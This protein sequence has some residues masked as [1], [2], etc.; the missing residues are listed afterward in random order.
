MPENEVVVRFSIVVPVYNNPRDLRECVGALLAE[1]GPDTEILV[2]D[3]A[4]TDDTAAVAADLDVRVLRLST[5]AG[6]G[7]A[8]NHGVRHARGDVVFFVDADVI[9]APGSVARVRRVFE[10]RPDVAAVFGSYDETPRAAGYVSRYRNLLHHFVHQNG[11]GE[12]STFWAGCGAIR[13]DVFLAIGGFDERRFPR[14]SIED[15]ELGLRLRR[16]GH[17]ILLDGTIQGTHLKQWSLVSMIRT[18]I[19]QRALPWS[20]LILESEGIPDTL[21]LKRDQRL[22]AALV[23]VTGLCLLLASIRMEF[24]IVAAATLAAVLVLN[25]ELYVFLFRRGG[26]WFATVS[27]ALHLLYFIYSVLSYGVA[28][29]ERRSGAALTPRA[30]PS[31]PSRS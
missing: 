15:I 28:W 14:P 5:N 31:A 21:N 27:I 10:E 22:S 29:L 4:S 7:G 11:H 20:R 9:I 8:R 12:A 16:S 26:V 25:R 6:P 19:T 24:A 13:R 2:V 17:T 1:S 30:R 23:L 18:D 3:D